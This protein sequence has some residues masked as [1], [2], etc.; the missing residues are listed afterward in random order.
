MPKVFYFLL[1]NKKIMCKVIIG[2]CILIT[3]H[4]EKLYKIIN[5]YAT[6]MLYNVC[7]ELE[8]ARHW[9]GILIFYKYFMIPGYL[10]QFT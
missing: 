1:K 3:K 9:L 2:N 10:T 7:L 5:K 8:L 6:T 4:A